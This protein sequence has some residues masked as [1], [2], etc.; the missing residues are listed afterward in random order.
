M[1]ITTSKLQILDYLQKITRGLRMNELGGFTTISISTALNISRSLTS[2]YLNEL[3]KEERIIKISTRPVYYMDCSVLERKYQLELKNSEYLSLRELMKELHQNSPRLQDFQKAI[4]CTGSLQYPI[5]QLKAALSYP[6]GGL[7]VILQGEKGCGKSYLVRLTHEFCLNRMT[8]LQKELPLV[9]KKA[10]RDE[11]KGRQMEELFGMGAVNGHPAVKGLLEE[12]DGGILCIQNAS[13]LSEECQEKL[14]DYLARSKFT[15]VH[16]DQAQIEAKVQII[17]STSEDPHTVFCHNLLLS[18]PVI[19]TIPSFQKRNEEERLEFVIKF[20]QEEQLRLERSIYISKRLQHFLMGYQFESNIDELRKCIRTICANAFADCTSKERMDIYLYHLP[21]H[22]LDH[23]TVDKNSRDRDSLVRIDTVEK[24]EA[25]SKILVMWEQLLQAFDDYIA[26]TQSFN[27]F[28]EQGQKALRYYYDIL[29]FQET[30]YDGRLEAMEKIVIEV[31]NSVKVIKNIN[32]PINCAYVL[33]RMLVSAQKNTSSLYEWEQDHQKDIQQCLKKMAGCMSNEYILTETIAR[34]L[35]ANIN[36]QLS[37]MN[38]IFL[39]LNIN[40]YNRDIRSQDTVG[41]ILSHGYSTASSIADAANSLLNSYTFEAIDMPLNTPV[42][43]ISG[44]LNDFIEENPHLKNIIL[45]VDMGSLEGIG[46]VIADSVNVGVI[47]NIST[48]LALNIGMKIQQ[49]YELEEL[50][51]LA[52]NEN[53]CRYKVLSEAKKEKAIVFTNDAGMLIS[54]KLCRLFKDSLPRPIDLKMIAYEFDELMK[55]R[56]DDILF[57]KYDVVLMIK[58]YS[59]KLKKVNSVTLEEIMNFEN[60]EQLNQ[61]FCP[62]LSNEEIEQFDQRLLKNFSM[63]SVM[64]NITILNADKLLDYVSDAVSALQQT[65]GKKFQSKTIVGIY[66]HICFLIERLVTK[67]AFE[68]YK[69]LSG[70]Q[71]KHRDFIDDVNRSFEIMLQHY[72]VRLPIS[73]IAYLFEYIENDLQKGG[74]ADE[75]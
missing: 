13:N 57:R 68:K 27:G 45:L 37:E 52:C 31:L 58:P 3:V 42:Q 15:R 35:H 6:Q 22:L 55:N 39:M 62:Y 59:L 26:G 69:D 44:K 36:M 48:S 28:L 12:A 25:G 73:E 2:Q 9:K 43:E 66:M 38:R 8:S 20:F 29:V 18:I 16:D 10:F 5:S 72:H 33:A 51:E 19:C 70:F 30:Y 14:A 71:E 47:N 23:L 17:L 32:L 65:M 7:P 53:Q 21:V 63:Q 4:G 60:I 54:E 34:Q 49:H 1:N 56:T 74:G 24:N 75:F 50:L 64:E 41:I 40:F 46:E 67:T 61:V 11:N